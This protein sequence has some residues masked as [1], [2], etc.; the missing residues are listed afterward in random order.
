MPIPR[1]RDSSEDLIA[2]RGVPKD[3]LFCHS[4]WFPVAQNQKV[5]MLEEIRRLP[6]HQVLNTSID[7][8]KLPP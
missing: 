8:L 6:E 7:D 1:L 4:E 5:R 2:M 3:Y